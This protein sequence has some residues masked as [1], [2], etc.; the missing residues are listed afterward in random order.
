MSLTQCL[1]LDLQFPKAGVISPAHASPKR[2]TGK[3]FFSSCKPKKS[4]KSMLLRSIGLCLK[5]SDSSAIEVP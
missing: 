3:A 2:C 4:E 1:K 5:L